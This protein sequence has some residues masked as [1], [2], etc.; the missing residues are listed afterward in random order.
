[1]PRPSSLF[2]SHLAKA[3]GCGI[4]RLDA[5]FKRGLHQRLV[6]PAA[7]SRPKLLLGDI[8]VL[9]LQQNGIDNPIKL[10]RLSD[11][12]LKVEV[13]LWRTPE[14]S[15]LAVKSL[16][17]RTAL[18]L[19]DL[20][21]L[22]GLPEFRGFGQGELLQHLHLPRRPDSPRHPARALGIRHD[23]IRR[24]CRR[25]S[26][27]RLTPRDRHKRHTANKRSRHDL[28]PPLRSASTHGG[29]AP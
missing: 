14:V 20:Q 9:N 5:V 26:G 29:W 23:S 22:N 4:C 1:M 18:G 19:L 3:R 12:I 17:S 8:G 16:Y 27:I 25:S 13:C 24:R 7:R 21:V 28:T 2:L 6:I 10:V 11:K 15:Q